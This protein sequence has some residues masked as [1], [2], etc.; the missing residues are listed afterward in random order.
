MSENLA[1]ELEY[2]MR[3]NDVLKRAI[4]DAYSTNGEKRRKTDEE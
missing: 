2:Q 4:E 3:E 1:E